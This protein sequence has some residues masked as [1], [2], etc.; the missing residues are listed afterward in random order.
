MNV[1]GVNSKEILELFINKLMFSECHKD[2][3]KIPDSPSPHWT[4]L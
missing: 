1:Y 2:E 3:V 4:R